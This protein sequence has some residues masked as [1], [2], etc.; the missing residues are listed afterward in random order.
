MY[1]L[2]N[3]PY[4]TRTWSTNGIHFANIV[5]I[6]RKEVNTT[7]STN[8]TSKK[9]VLIIRSVRPRPY[10]FPK[11]GQFWFYS[12]LN[13]ENLGSMCRTVLGFHPY[14]SPPHAIYTC[15]FGSMRKIPRAFWHVPY[16]PPSLRSNPPYYLFTPGNEHHFIRPWINLQH[17]FGHLRNTINTSII[18]LGHCSPMMIL[19]SLVMRTCPGQRFIPLNETHLLHHHIDLED[20]FQMTGDAI[21]VISNGNTSQ[22]FDFSW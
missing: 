16:I 9:L 8:S 13:L 4:T 21:D 22:P 5:R 7:I 1:Q 6:T 2:I 11:Q 3:V 10:M 20:R 14:V 17:P 19:P 18:I 12:R 15:V